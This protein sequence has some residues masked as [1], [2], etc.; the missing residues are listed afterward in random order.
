MGKVA[1][2]KGEGKCKAKKGRTHPH[3]RFLDPLRLDQPVLH[4]VGD[5]ARVR[6]AAGP[7]GH[8]RVGCQ[9]EEGIVETVAGETVAVETVDGGRAYDYRERGLEG[10]FTCNRVRGFGLKA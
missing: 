1:R 2:S 5:Q 10:I 4:Q 8:V 9:R 3:H 7:P 6:G